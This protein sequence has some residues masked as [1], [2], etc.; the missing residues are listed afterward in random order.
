VLYTGVMTVGVN[1]EYFVFHGLNQH[2][3]FLVLFYFF[4]EKNVSDQSVC[5]VQHILSCPIMLYK[6]SFSFLF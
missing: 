6:L 4:K 2:R 1:K 5:F 3:M